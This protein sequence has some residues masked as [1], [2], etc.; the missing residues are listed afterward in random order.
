[1]SRPAMSWEIRKGSGASPTARR[2]R[3][4]CTRKDS[5]AK[6]S[7]V[8]IANAAPAV[9]RKSKGDVSSGGNRGEAYATP[10]N[11]AA[12]DQSAGDAARRMMRAATT[13]AHIKS[14]A[15]T[16]GRT[17]RARFR[18]STSGAV[19]R[20]TATARTVMAADS[21]AACQRARVA[22][23]S[24]ESIVAVS[25]RF[26]AGSSMANVVAPSAVGSPS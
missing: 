23:R 7:S 3:R 14:T 13:A 8:T 25:R 4:S 22:A 10:E 19:S 12:S 24:S 16:Y 6:S 11:T 2:F 9:S 5:I 15:V 26:P 1:M 18:Q 21:V 17:D 20:S